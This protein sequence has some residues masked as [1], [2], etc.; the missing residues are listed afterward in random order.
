LFSIIGINNRPSGPRQGKNIRKIKKKA[1][2]SE[3]TLNKEAF[4][5]VSTLIIQIG[6][7]LKPAGFREFPDNSLG[8]DSRQ[9]LAP[10]GVGAWSGGREFAP[11]TV[12]VAR[13]TG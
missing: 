2:Y 9:S 12:P 3:K 8:A 7:I 13:G 4:L 6:K 1:I 10:A 5:T 11:A